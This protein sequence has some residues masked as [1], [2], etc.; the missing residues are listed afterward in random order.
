MPS[1]SVQKMV[2]VFRGQATSGAALLRWELGGPLPVKP[3]SITRRV[4]VVLAIYRGERQ[5]S[6]VSDRGAEAA[7]RK[8]GKSWI[9]EEERAGFQL[10][11][12]T[13]ISDGPA[14]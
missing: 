6:N 11:C 8:K 5:R 3:A 7:P 13:G 1:L 10:C 9:K 12:D 2:P 14:F 4:D